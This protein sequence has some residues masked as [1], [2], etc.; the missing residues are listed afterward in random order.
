MDGNMARLFFGLALN[1]EARAAAAEAARLLRFGS[2]RPSDA[3]NYHLTLVFL[4]MTPREAVPE[5]SALAGRVMGEPF[6]LT[7]SG[8]LG[9]FRDGSV[10]W[11]GV[12]EC[13]AL[14]ELRRRL[15]RAL[16]EAGFPD[17]GEP[18]RPHITLGRNMKG[19]GPLPGAARA[20]F[21]VERVTLF[22]STREAGRLVYRPLNG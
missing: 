2:G 9:T 7:L 8:R 18:Y 22:E 3:D 16:A 13:A 15:S 19:L 17:G 20:S 14:Y 10:V 12:E 4:G 11:A 5:L 1:D 6:R 21:P